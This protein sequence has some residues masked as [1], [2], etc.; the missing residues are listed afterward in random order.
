MLLQRHDFYRSCMAAEELELKDGAQ[1]MLLS[2]LDLT[3]QEDRKLANGRRVAGGAAR[4]IHHVDALLTRTLTCRAACVSLR[5]RGYVT[6]FLAAAT[7][8]S[9]LRAEIKKARAPA[10]AHAR[11]HACPAP[12]AERPVHRR[13]AAC[14]WS[15]PSHRTATTT[16]KSLTTATGAP[17]TSARASWRRC[18]RAGMTGCRW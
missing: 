14:S 11:T 13:P 18:R 5:S 8:R 15:A 9:A 10:A 7:C 4:H 12:P 2:N 17:S 6:G 1:V 16:L 3:S